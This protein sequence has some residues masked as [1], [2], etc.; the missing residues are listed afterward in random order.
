MLVNLDFIS[1]AV[2]CRNGSVS[3]GVKAQSKETGAWEI[4]AYEIVLERD[5]VSLEDRRDRGKRVEKN[6]IA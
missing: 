2:E 5:A 6:D 4:V 1:A 3:G